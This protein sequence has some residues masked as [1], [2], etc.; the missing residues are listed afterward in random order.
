MARFAWE[1]A[2]AFVAGL[3][4][5][6]APELWADATAARQ[7]LM[8]L[9]ALLALSGLYALIGAAGPSAWTTTA[10]A[11]LT[12]GS[13]WAFGFTG[14]GSA[15]WTAWLAGGAA[16]IV[17]LWTAVQTTTAEQA[18]SEQVNA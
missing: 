11:V 7:P 12:F 18:G 14:E 15:A 2:V 9:G 3:V 5:V 4:A 1:D 6:L 13:P 10:F 17:G 16:A 8:V